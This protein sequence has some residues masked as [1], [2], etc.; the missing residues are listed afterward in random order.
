M[1]ITFKLTSAFGKSLWMVLFLF[2]S[3][4]FQLRAQDSLATVYFYRPSKLDGSLVGFEIKQRDEVIGRAK[5]NSVFTYRTKP[6]EQI[7]KATTETESSFR[8]T[9]DV[10]KTYFVECGIAVGVAVGRP[11]FRLASSAEAKNEIA[12]IENT[13]RQ[14]L[15]SKII[16]T[17][18]K[19]Q[20]VLLLE[21]GM[22]IAYALHGDLTI[23][24]GIINTIDKTFVVVD[25]RT[26]AYED[27]SLIGRRRSGSG[28]FQFFCGFVGGGLIFSS[29]SPA[30]TPQCHGC[31]VESSVDTGAVVAGVLLGAGMIGVG[32]NSGF[33]NSPKDVVTKWKL[34]VE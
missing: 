30:P 25:N 24:K 13:K 3:I 14:G 10:G 12:K 28:F 29:L 4:P 8:L 16:L 7:F 6:G 11:T 32:I 9:V 31:Q 22:R 17:N 19:T 33:R 5:P 26:L 27:L 21:E 18:I 23:K 34:E 2:L 15:Y 20:K 1:N